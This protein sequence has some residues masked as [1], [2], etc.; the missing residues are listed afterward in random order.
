MIEDNDQDK[1]L[2][3]IGEEL[4]GLIDQFLIGVANKSIVE[5]IVVQD[6]LL[7]LRN[8]ISASTARDGDYNGDE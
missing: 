1:E 7:D 4:L 8:I 6:F 2:L 3:A 5:A